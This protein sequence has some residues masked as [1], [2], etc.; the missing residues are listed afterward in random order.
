MV[1]QYKV[2]ILGATGMVGQRFAVLLE[3]HPWF[4]V[5]ELV[6]SERS[7]GKPYGERANWVL[8]DPMPKELAGKEIKLADAELDCDLCFSAIPAGTAGPIE[9][10]LA[11]RGYKVFTNARDHRWD[12][13]VPL[14]VPEVNPDH[15]VLVERQKATYGGGCIVAGG[16]CSTIVMVMTLKPLA[17]AF[18]I[19]R[20]N[21][22]TFQA[23]SG[24][25]YPGVPSLDI[26][27][28]VIPF[29][30]GEEEKVEREPLKMLGRLHESAIEPAPFT[31]SATCVR[32]PVEEAHSEDIRVTLRRGATPEEVAAA[33]R[34]WRAEPQQR[35]LPSAPASPLLV[36]SEANRPQPR[37]DWR[38]GNG[39]AVT[40]GRIRKDPHGTV[41]YFA[42]GSNTVRGAAGG[43][44]LGA[45]LLVA[46]GLC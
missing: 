32:V 37:K 35:K 45:E 27:G 38:A 34:D 10:S 24:A 2:G 36:A 46:R 20:V 17:D 14:L 1:Q 8:N 18:G 42:S 16:N 23:I 39:M 25:G 43:N 5:T 33:M 41:K 22:T 26:L 6:A 19:E 3:R 31:V 4:K 11:K 30:G 40:V 13:D 21:V 7:A 28:N 9:S 12:P 15:S 29:I 44:I